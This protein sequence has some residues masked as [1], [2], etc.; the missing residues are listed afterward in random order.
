M[1]RNPKGFAPHG[2]KMRAGK[3]FI[4]FPPSAARYL[5]AVGEKN[6][7]NLPTAICMVVMAAMRADGDWVPRE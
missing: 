3:F 5:A 2:D 4:S 6:G 7:V 1:S